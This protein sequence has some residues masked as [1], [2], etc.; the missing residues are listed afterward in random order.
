[1]NL[2]D[3]LISYNQV[4][5]PK[6]EQEPEIITVE[7]PYERLQ[8]FNN[9]KKEQEAQPDPISWFKSESKPQQV[10]MPT[11]KKGSAKERISARLKS[12]G[13]NNIQIQSIIG[14]LQQE[15]GLNPN[16]ISKDGHNSYGLAQWTGNRKLRLFSQKGSNPSIEDQVDFLVEELN[17][18]EKKALNAIKNVKTVEEGVKA[19]MDTFERPNAKYANLQN[20]I[21]YAKS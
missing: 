14:N 5:V 3:L 10:S 7:S 20:R 12:H 11:Y 15:S 6:F 21:K 19:F 9:N 1:M 4:T 8:S 18:S 2:S 17:T 13:F 16:S